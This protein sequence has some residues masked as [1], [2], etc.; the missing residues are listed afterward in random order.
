MN[1]ITNTLAFDHKCDDII[2]ISLSKESKVIITMT[3]ILVFS[4]SG[5]EVINIYHIHINYY[6]H[7]YI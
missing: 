4:S 3:N 7:Q 1:N 5:I 6:N 2:I